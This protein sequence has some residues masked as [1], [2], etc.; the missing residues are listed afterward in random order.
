MVITVIT[1][2][3]TATPTLYAVHVKATDTF[4]AVLQA[5]S[6]S[7]G[8]WRFA[9]VYDRQVVR[10]I[11]MDRE[12]ARVRDGTPLFLYE[13]TTVEGEGEEEEEGELLA[14]KRV[15]YK[16]PR[17][18]EL[19]ACVVIRRPVEGVVDLLLTFNGM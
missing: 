1:R 11:P 4:E 13:S 12:I 3:A 6:Y 15:I 18:D 16:N 14:G 10:H 7:K 8:D 17:T 5:L 2:C 9:E 19:H